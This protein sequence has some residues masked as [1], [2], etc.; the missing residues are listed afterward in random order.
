M[1]LPEAI[2]ISPFIRLKAIKNSKAT[3]TILNNNTMVDDAIVITPNRLI[4][5]EHK[6][7]SK[8]FWI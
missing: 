8:G 3:S 2:C 4:D 6:F 7:R 5:D 1:F